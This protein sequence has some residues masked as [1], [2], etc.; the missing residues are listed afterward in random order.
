MDGPDDGGMVVRV[1]IDLTDTGDGSPTTM[2]LTS[3]YIQYTQ[4]HNNRPPSSRSAARG[5]PSPA[6]RCARCP[7]FTSTG[8]T[9]GM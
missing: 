4:T 5:W 9:T 8:Q 6:T 3:M 1:M 2:V 7:C